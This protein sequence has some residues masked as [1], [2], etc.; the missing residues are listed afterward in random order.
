MLRQCLRA[1]FA[2]VQELVYETWVVD[3]GSS[4]GSTEM[5]SV[6]FPQVELICNPENLGFARANN[7][8]LRLIRGRYALL[9]NS[10]AFLTERAVAALVS[11]LEADPTVGIAGARLVYPDG[12]EQ[13]SYGRVPTL[14]SEMGSLI[15]LDKVWTGNSQGKPDLKGKPDGERREKGTQDGQ[16]R[17]KRRLK[18]LKRPEIDI[19]DVRETGV[20][21]GACLLARRAMLDQVGLLD[22]RYFMFSEEVDLCT[23]AQEIGWK[24]M[25]VP[26]ALVVHVGG[27]SSGLTAR[28]VLDLYLGKRQFFAKHYGRRKAHR[29]LTMMRVTSWMKVGL[30]QLFDRQRVK[31]WR[32]I[33][34][35]LGE[36][37][38]L[39]LVM[40]N[41]MKD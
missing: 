32:D 28:R 30:Y 23:R 17:E 24:V 41:Q 39:D 31:L 40:N 5:V 38:I 25:Y 9:L 33:T 8:A 19:F 7:L 6:E 21:S 1:V 20:V 27:G 16:A 3:N 10:D 11:L 26:G 29:L 22:E 13:R 12:R 36:S 2:T 4:D 15:G 34:K 37:V 18:S 14:W 35:G